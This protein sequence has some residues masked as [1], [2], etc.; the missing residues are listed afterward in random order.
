MYVMY[1]KRE[2]KPFEIHPTQWKSSELISVNLWTG[3]SKLKL[4][5]TIPKQA[6]F[7]IIAFI[8]RQTKCIHITHIIPWGNS[9]CFTKWKKNKLNKQGKTTYTEKNTSSKFVILKWKLHLVRLNIETF[10]SNQIDNLTVIPNLLSSKSP[11]FL[12]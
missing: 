4:Y 11:P 3:I 12:T 5:Y 10:Q 7:Y 8:T 9:R 6:S 2:K 1:E